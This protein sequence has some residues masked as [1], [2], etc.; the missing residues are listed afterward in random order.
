[1]P[2]INIKPFREKNCETGSE[3]QTKQILIREAGCFAGILKTRGE[4]DFTGLIFTAKL[5]A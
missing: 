3:I 5:F 1:V 4:G 2:E